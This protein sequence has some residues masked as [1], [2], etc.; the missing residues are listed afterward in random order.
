MENANEAVRVE[1]NTQLKEILELVHPCKCEACSI[2]CKYGSG[3]LADEDFQ[4]IAKFLEVS[5][6]EL[7]K[8]FLEEIEKFNTKRYRPK[9]LRKGKPHGKCTFYDEKIGCKIHEV[10][11]LECRVSMGCKSYGSQLSVWFMLNHF[12]NKND[13]ESIRQYAS[14]LKIG[15]EV[16]PGAELEKLVPDKEKLRKILAFEI[17]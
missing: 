10:K 8:E 3:S 5:E 11:P 4:K 7:K 12:V 9:I 14:Y 1:K 15:G 2:G 17:Q 6:E 16:L 13:A